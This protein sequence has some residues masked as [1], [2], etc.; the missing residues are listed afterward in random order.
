MRRESRL[1]NSLLVLLVV[2]ALTGSGCT[3][4]ANLIYPS[5]SGE[6]AYNHI[7]ELSSE[8]YQGRLP[9]QIGNA[10]AAA[11]IEEAFAELNLTPGGDYRTYYQ[12]FDPLDLSPAQPGDH[13]VANVIGLL[14]APGATDTVIISAHFDHLGVRQSDRSVYYGA[15]DNASGVGVMLEL[16]RAIVEHG[17]ALPFNVEFVAFN[18]EEGGLIG[19][20]YYLRTRQESTKSILAALN[21]DVV[22]LAENATL[23]ILDAAAQSSLTKALQ[24]GSKQINI[25]TRWEGYNMRSDHAPFVAAGIPSITLLHYS[26]AYFETSYHSPLDTIALISIEKLKEPAELILKFLYDLASTYTGTVSHLLEPH[27]I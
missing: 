8:R 3:Q 5:F 4:H 9:G 11:Y 20:S 10:L 14:A 7:A 26:T 15:V 23:T 18:S 27:R 22:G 13:A 24:L 6:L 21:M 1:V 19:S 16:A 25:K 12:Y 17:E 2:V